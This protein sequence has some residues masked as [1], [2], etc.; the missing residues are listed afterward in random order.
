MPDDAQAGSWWAWL[1]RWL[2]GAP[3]SGQG[4]AGMREPKQPIVV[5]FDASVR[6][7]EEPGGTELARSYFR[8]D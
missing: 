4:S 1:L 3:G 5:Q 6:D 7:G 2:P 8:E